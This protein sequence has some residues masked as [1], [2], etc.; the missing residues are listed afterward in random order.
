[1]TERSPAPRK[2]LPWYPDAASA[3][4]GLGRTKTYQLI[5]SGQLKSVTIGRRRFVD[6]RDIE[7][8]I[9]QRRSASTV[10]GGEAA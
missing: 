9:D 10:P 1:M 7:E 4:G 5:K 2:L 3:L 8:F 6:A